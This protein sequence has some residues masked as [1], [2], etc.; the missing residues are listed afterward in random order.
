MTTRRWILF[1]GVILSLL[2]AGLWLLN[3]LGGG[4][5]VTVAANTIASSTLSCE[6]LPTTDEAEA[7]VAANEGLFE[8][9]EAVNPDFVSVHVLPREGCPDRALLAIAYAT[10]RDREAIEA[11]LRE[12]AGYSRPGLL[13]LPWLFDVPV[14]LD[15][16]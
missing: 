10:K 1:F 15:N 5:L 12:S 9:V 11:I 16:T 8:Q 13:S 4:I 2:L 7:V 14:R 3:L 6:Q